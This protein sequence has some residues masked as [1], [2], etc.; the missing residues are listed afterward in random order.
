MKDDALVEE[1]VRL[2]KIKHEQRFSSSPSYLCIRIW[3]SHISRSIQL[4]HTTNDFNLHPPQR[5]TQKLLSKKKLIDG[6]KS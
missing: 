4:A 2:H 1:H 6:Q 5:L 3:V